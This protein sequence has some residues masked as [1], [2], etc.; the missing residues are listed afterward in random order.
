MSQVDHVEGIDFGKEDSYIVGKFNA[1]DALEML[2]IPVEESDEWLKR[3]VITAETTAKNSHNRPFKKGIG[4]RYAHDI[5]HGKWPYNGES[6]S[7]SKTRQIISG[8]HRLYGLLRAEK[9]R[10]LNPEAYKQWHKGPIS[11][12][13]LLATGI[14]DKVAD[15]TDQGQPRAHGDMLFRKGLFDGYKMADKSQEFKLSD[16][17]ALA[18]DLATALRTVWLRVGGKDVSDAP[19]FPKSEMLTFLAKHPK[20]IDCVVYVYRANDGKNKLIAST[21]SRAYMAAV[22][23]L[24]AT[25][26]SDR[27]DYDASGEINTDFMD[28]AEDFVECYANGLNMQAGSPILALKNTFNKQKAD[29]GTRDRDVTLNLTCKAF[30]LFLDGKNAETKL[31]THKKDDPTPRVGGLDVDATSPENDEDK[32]TKPAPA[33]PAKKTAKPAPAKPAKKTTSKKA[34]VVAAPVES[35]DDDDTGYSDDDDVDDDDMDD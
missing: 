4:D 16:K 34:K 5:L 11:I 30:A 6:L 22:M 10:K 24:A 14:D 3:M 1:K 25:S 15:T 2:G 29:G 28:K 32:P 35:E 12:K 33:K 21:I 20:V 13:I 23:Y 27:E 8:Q 31:F 7:I 17:K 18:K 19:H 26:A 9:L